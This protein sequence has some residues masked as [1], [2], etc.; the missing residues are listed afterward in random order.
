MD[1]WQLVTILLGLI[2]AGVGWWVRNIW[3]MVTKQQEMII[4]LQ[5]ELARSYV[6]RV[7]LQETFTRIFDALEDIRKEVA[8]R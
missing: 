6:P 3:A 4:G 5:V 1:P 7:E 8:K 2:T